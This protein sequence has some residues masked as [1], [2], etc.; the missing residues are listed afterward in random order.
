MGGLGETEGLCHLILL[1]LFSFKPVFF[2]INKT[3]Y[4]FYGTTHN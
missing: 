2:L 1:D 4:I 3:D